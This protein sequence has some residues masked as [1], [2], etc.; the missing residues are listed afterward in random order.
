MAS[1]S[2]SWADRPASLRCGS[3]LAG[4]NRRSPRI[5]AVRSSGLKERSIASTCSRASR[6]FS[7]SPCRRSD[8][9]LRR[10][11]IDELLQFFSNSQVVV[12]AENHRYA[13]FGRSTEQGF[14]LTQ[15]IA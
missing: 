15:K 8:P 13:L 7:L 11:L 10:E 1:R 3:A 4:T 14:V 12:V 9:E 5:K 6:T 2:C